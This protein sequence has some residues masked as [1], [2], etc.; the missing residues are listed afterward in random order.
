MMSEE[1]SMSE[2]LEDQNVIYVT[3]T[4]I[5]TSTKNNL[6]NQMNISRRLQTRLDQRI[7]QRIIE[8][9]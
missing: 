6:V 5:C 3:G 2:K 8:I 4:L 7:S 9:V 1:E